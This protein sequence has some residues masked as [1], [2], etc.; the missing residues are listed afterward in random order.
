MKLASEGVISAAVERFVTRAWI[1]R[2][3][4]VIGS[5]STHGVIYDFLKKLKRNPG[6]LEVLGDGTQRKPYL[7]VS[8]LIDAMLLVCEKARERLQLLQHR[9][10][11][12][13]HHGPPH[14]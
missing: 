8:E 14:R 12:Q 3:P 4:N 9:H 6:E 2:F 5:R 11:R 7:H 1:F 10:P 13:Q